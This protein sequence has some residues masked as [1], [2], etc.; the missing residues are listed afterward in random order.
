MI[1]I[2]EGVL[3]TQSS[4]AATIS[5]VYWAILGDTVIRRA[6]LDGTSREELLRTPG[7]IQ[8]DIA[9]D[10]VEK[11]MYW[12][13]PEAGGIQRANLDGSDIETVVSGIDEPLRVALDSINRKVYW[14]D[15]AN[16]NQLWRSS[17]DGTDRELLFNDIPF[18]T[19]IEVDPLGGF[20]YW[21]EKLHGVIRRTALDLSLTEIVLDDMA[22]GRGPLPTGIA[23]DL[24]EGYLYATDLVFNAIVRVGLD[25]SNPLLW[26]S[27]G[28]EFPES[29]AF[30]PLGQRVYW[31]NSFPDKYIMSAN[32]DG[33]DVTQEFLPTKFGGIGADNAEHL[34]ILN[35]PIPEP[36]T[37]ILFGSGAMIL[38]LLTRAQERERL[39]CRI[40]ET[41]KACDYRV[42]GKVRNVQWQHVHPR[43]PMNNGMKLSGN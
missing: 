31:A 34:A 29:V 26:L 38:L 5:K 8:P 11:K 36:R 33:D 19:A 30:D 24:S 6:N 32:I 12:P 15:S 21:S 13:S 27:E 43:R 35:L 28:V 23:L 17:L 9:F 42:W 20:F 3:F 22:F 4:E 16:P 25:G 18:I 40:K 2:F 1:F 14:F 10:L 39:F 7:G 37:T 41:P